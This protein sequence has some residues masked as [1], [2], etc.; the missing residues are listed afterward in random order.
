MR[1]PRPTT[2][3]RSPTI[4]GFSLVELLAVLSVT[5][6]LAAV[7]IPRL[8]AASDARHAAAAR[9]AL[10]DLTQARERAV[11][12]AVPVWIAFDL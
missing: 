6:I 9:L 10:R 1:A 4:G 5:A 2:G 3:P 7:A 11:A 8:A 12:T